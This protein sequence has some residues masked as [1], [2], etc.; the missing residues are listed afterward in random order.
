MKSMTKRSALDG[1]VA[2]MVVS[3][4]CI[5]CQADTHTWKSTGRVN[6]WNWNDGGNF[7]EGVAPQAGDNVKLPA[8]TDIFATNAASIELVSSLEQVFPVDAKSRI[9]FSVAEGETFSITNCAIC[10][11]ATHDNSDYK[12]GEI[13]KRG[14]GTLILARADGHQ[15]QN[16]REP[17]YTD[18]N[19][20]KTDIVV[21]SGVLKLPTSA[22]KGGYS[23]NFG[24]ISV[25]NGAALFTVSG[26]NYTQPMAIWGEGVI[27]NTDSVARNLRVNGTAA[28]ACVFHGSIGGSI[29][30][31]S[32]GN[33]TLLGT[34]TF[35]GNLTAYCSS[36][37]K[38]ESLNSNHSRTAFA[39]IGK[40]NTLGAVPAAKTELI[41][42]F[43]GGRFA[44]IGD[45]ADETDRN[46]TVSRPRGGLCV[47]DGGHHGELT[48]SGTFTSAT[49]VGNLGMAM[50]GLDGSNEYPCVFS[51]MVNQIADTNDFFFVKV[52]SGAWRF[53][54]TNRSFNTTVTV[55]EGTLQF[56][57]LAE[58][59]VRCSLGTATNRSAAY[60]GGLTKAFATDYAILAG[61]TLTAPAVLEYTGTKF[62][63]SVATRQVG[64]IGDLSLK[65]DTALPWRH[66]GFGNATNK[67][68]T[69]DLTGAGTAENVAQGICDTADTPITVTK[70]GSGTWVLDGS[71]TIH[72]AIAVKGGTLKVRKAGG[73]YRWFRWSI[74]GTWESTRAGIYLKELGLY[75]GNGNRVNASLSTENENHLSL[76]PGQ[77]ALGRHDMTLNKPLANAVDGKTAYLEFVVSSGTA[78]DPDKESSWWPILMRLPEGSAMAESFDLAVSHSWN[79]TADAKRVPKSWQMEGSVDG[80]HWDL[81]S[82]TNNAQPMANIWVGRGVT[83]G[84]DASDLP[85]V[86][87]MTFEKTSVDIATTVLDS[88]STVSVATNCTLETSDALALKA[89][90]LDAV[91]NGTIKGFVFAEKGMIDVVNLSADVREIEF[92]ATFTD[93]TGLKNL[94]SWTLTV[95]GASAASRCLMVS[96]AGVVRI[97][98][99]GIRVIVR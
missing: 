29:A 53:S 58:A 89:L 27:T 30:Y 67:A 19:A 47:I 14:R 16:S 37:L 17:Y 33:V 9:V 50:V 91:G 32:Y 82:E 81:I 21:E 45:V 97:V 73:A 70:S 74:R 64:L 59:G 4:V 18:R 13:V 63:V 54:E 5:S 23:H 60:Y 61:A 11:A 83:Y 80:I 78:P 65:N 2:A 36:A 56:D 95:D 72:G 96:D 86:G 42:A 28:D 77:I 48:I 20:Y 88:V 69:L 79:V 3:T 43:N 41:F 6:D 84:G 34:N 49:D 87:G 1:I 71:N 39:K 94:Q 68:V 99:K 46:I 35:T 15:D 51:G 55:R 93:V 85:H 8:T 98:P 90:T 7:E 40:K 92:D 62:G 52:G 31:E 76:A 75:D 22:E 66:S 25:S 38:I 26:G 12:I 24:H 44:Y 10:S 57:S